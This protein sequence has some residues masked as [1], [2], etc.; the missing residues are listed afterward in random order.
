MSSGVSL[1]Q[2]FIIIFVFSVLILPLA[3][4]LL[5][6]RTHGGAKAGWLIAVLMFSLIAYAV[7]LIVTQGNV[8]NRRL[9]EPSR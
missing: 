4:V 3:H 5:S 1:W 7:F 6:P 8:D 9:E 2:L